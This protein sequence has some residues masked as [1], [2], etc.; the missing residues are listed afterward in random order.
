MKHSL[1]QQQIETLEQKIFN[2]Q[3]CKE[4]YDL[5]QSKECNC[6]VLGF[7]FDH[8]L[9]SRIC[10][11]CEAPGIFKPHKGEVLIEK[12]DD[13]HEIYD[14]RIQ[15]V[16][17]IGK[18]LFNIFSKASLN[19]TDIQ[20]FNVVCCSPPNYRQPQID[21]IEN[22]KSFLSDR[23]SLMQN[24]KVIVAF[25]KVSRNIVRQ[26]NLSTP[27]V[28]SHHPSYIYSYMPEEDRLAYIETIAN[29]IKDILNGSHSI[30]K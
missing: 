6:P 13:F 10:S 25:G 14:N 30:N 9:N 2:C 19:W 22:C 27:I 24:L 12:L 29:N 11:I 18:R 3:N 21:E 20:H 1:L 23:L 26:F 5:R 7:N 15:N 17:L 16:A 28:Y 8:Y 4:L